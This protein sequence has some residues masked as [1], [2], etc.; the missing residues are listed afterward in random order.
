MI[1]LEKS[2]S[3]ESFRR[4]LSKLSIDSEDTSPDYYSND[5]SQIVLIFKKNKP[6][7]AIYISNIESAISREVIDEYNIQS[8]VNLAYIDKRGKYPPLEGIGYINVK[9][10]DKT[11]ENFIEI[12]K[13]AIDF[14]DSQ[15]NQGKN[16]LIHCLEGKSRSVS[17]I[18]A[19][20]MIHH[21]DWVKSLSDDFGSPKS[22]HFI[23]PYII[24]GIS[25]N[26]CKVL[27]Y[28]YKLKPNI[29]PNISILEQLNTIDQQNY[30]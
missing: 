25:T 18:I 16:I 23:N 13:P 19:Y 9:L 28:I 30:K 7:S 15:Y 3:Y 24:S 17:T 6:D 11:G 1:K 10:K 22:S 21:Y 20:L 26:T 2:N 27:H 29:D 12:I 5:T 14:I 8:I 4:K